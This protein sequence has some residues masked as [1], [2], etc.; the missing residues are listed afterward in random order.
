MITSKDVSSYLTTDSKHKD[1]FDSIQS[2]LDLAIRAKGEEKI[3]VLYR[4][5]AENR[6]RIIHGNVSKS[7]VFSDLV[8]L[9]AR[10]YLCPTM[11]NMICLSH[12]TMHVAVGPSG[13]IPPKMSRFFLK[14]LD[15]AAT[16]AER[17]Q[18][19]LNET[20]YRYLVN[21][22]V[23]FVVVIVHLVSILCDVVCFCSQGLLE[24]H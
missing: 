16:D 13:L 23:D 2:G 7:P 12:T 14:H 19:V 1:A 18:I 11:H 6:L 17:G 3:T 5:T 9:D 4:K 21:K 24:S 20:R 22:Y 10:Y 8:R 15:H